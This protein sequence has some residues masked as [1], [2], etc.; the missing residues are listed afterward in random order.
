MQEKFPNL[1]GKDKNEKET[2]MTLLSN[3]QGTDEEFLRK[4]STKTWDL[5]K[6]D[7][8]NVDND[9]FKSA[10]NARL[11]ELRILLKMGNIF[12][13]TGTIEELQQDFDKKKIEVDWQIPEGFQVLGAKGIWN[14]SNQSQTP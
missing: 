11:R 9:E 1:F 5:L 3:C 12:L 6:D 10:E 7:L 2:V 13:S 8:K 14:N 4:L